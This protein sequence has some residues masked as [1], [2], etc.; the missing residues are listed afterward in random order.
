MHHNHGYQYTEGRRREA[1]TRCFFRAC[2]YF[3]RLSITATVWAPT[4]LSFFFL[5]FHFPVG[6]VGMSLLPRSWG[7]QWSVRSQLAPAAHAVPP[8]VAFGARRIPSPPITLP[9][10]RLTRVT[11]R[12]MVSATSRLHGAII[13]Q[14]HPCSQPQKLL[15]K[16]S[17]RG[18]K[19]SER[20][21]WRPDVRP[22][23]VRQYRISRGYHWMAKGMRLIYFSCRCET[24]PTRCDWLGRRGGRE[25]D[26]GLR[27]GQADARPSD[28]AGRSTSHSQYEAWRWP[29]ADPTGTFVWLCIELRN[30]P[31]LRRVVTATDPFPSRTMSTCSRRTHHRRC[32]RRLRPVRGARQRLGIRITCSRRL[33]GHESGLRQN[34][35]L[36]PRSHQVD[37]LRRLSRPRAQADGPRGLLR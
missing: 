19:Y 12:S 17:L 24:S 30:S 1:L 21:C 11:G 13:E 32:H 28:D 23:K 4:S 15:F 31:N 37:H 6:A 18:P 20:R 5:G 7:G 22:Q 35:R 33:Y 3:G 2:P 10:V 34:W 27:N 36:Q 9:S 16:S 26:D 8:W 29:R 14:Y 25:R